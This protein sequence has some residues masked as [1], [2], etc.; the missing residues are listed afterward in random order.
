M[1]GAPSPRWQCRQQAALMDCRWPLLTAHTI[2]RKKNNALMG[3]G[4]RFHD[5]SSRLSSLSLGKRQ[6]FI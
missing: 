1:E 6:I 4:L 5:H 3:S 2:A